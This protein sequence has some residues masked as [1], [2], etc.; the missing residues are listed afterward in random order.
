MIIPFLNSGTYV[1]V[2]GRYIQEI[3]S[4]SPQA[5]AIPQ[6]VLLVREDKVHEKYSSDSKAVFYN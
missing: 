1:N 4:F 2:L 3:I 5:L 6:L